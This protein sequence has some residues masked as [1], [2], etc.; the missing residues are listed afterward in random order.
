MTTLPL[1]FLSNDSNSPDGLTLPN[2]VLELF[3]PHVTCLELSRHYV[4]DQQLR[5]SSFMAFGE[6]QYGVL[7]QT[8][9]SGPL[10]S[11]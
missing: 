1:A 2:R 8:I 3:L 11:I 10:Q 7:W 5:E 4:G 9:M 6:A